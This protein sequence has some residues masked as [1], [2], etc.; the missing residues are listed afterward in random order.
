M[1][2]NIFEELKNLLTEFKTFLDQN[3]PTIRPAIQQIAKMFSQIVELIDKLIELMNKLK[4]EISNFDIS[5]IPGLAEDVTVDL[6]A[7]RQEPRGR[8]DL[9]RVADQRDPV[10]GLKDGYGLGVGHERLPALD[11]DD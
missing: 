4:T 8:L 2:T 6:I 3:V 5:N 9:F 1:D 10:T 7:R 11:G